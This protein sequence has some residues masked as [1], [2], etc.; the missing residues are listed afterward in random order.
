MSIRFCEFCSTVH[1]DG[2]THCPD[3]G[4][5]LIQAVP[6][7]QFNDPGNPWPFVPVSRL[8]LRIQGQPRTLRFSGTHSVYHLWS[9]LHSHFDDLSLYCRVK[10]G[11][12]ELAT[13]PR[14]RQTGNFRLLDP[15]MLLGCTHRRFSVYSYQAADPEVSPGG[16]LEMT[17]Q[18]SFEI[19]DCPPHALGNVLGWLVGTA[20]RPEPDNGWTYDI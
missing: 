12:L 19:E 15:G 1:P 8:C 14:G 7:E 5:R 20:P 11:E 13:F 9:L 18:G 16:T 4:A 17:Y 10:K 3:C 6:E 2:A